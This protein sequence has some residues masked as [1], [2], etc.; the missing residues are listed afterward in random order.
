MAASKSFCTENQIKSDGLQHIADVFIMSCRIQ[1]ADNDHDPRMKG[2]NKT[3]SPA[4]A[5]RTREAGGGEDRVPGPG[6]C[7]RVERQA[8][9]QR[10]APLPRHAG[11]LAACKHTSQGG[12]DGVNNETR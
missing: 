10:A 7:L 3:S 9:Q 2:T 11:C 12:K 6:L 5:A 8:R 4:P 1:P